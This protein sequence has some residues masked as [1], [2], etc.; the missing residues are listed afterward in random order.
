METNGLLRRALR[1]PYTLPAI[2]NDSSEEAT[3]CSS[4]TV[5]SSYAPLIATKILVMKIYS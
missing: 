2:L 1:T 3:K 5:R 4:S